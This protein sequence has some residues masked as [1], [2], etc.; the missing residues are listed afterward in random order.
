MGSAQQ[1]QSQEAGQMLQPAKVPGM[2]GNRQNRDQHSEGGLWRTGGAGQGARPGLSRDCP[3]GVELM[4]RECEAQAMKVRSDGYCAERRQRLDTWDR[5]TEGEASLVK[6][7]TPRF[8]GKI[9]GCLGGIWGRR[10][11]VEDTEPYGGLLG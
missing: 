6:V 9:Q 3:S 2:L 8:L 11:C 4:H 1:R 5:E 7:T 10:K